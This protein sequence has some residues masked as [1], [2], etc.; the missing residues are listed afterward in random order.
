MRRQGCENRKTLAERFGDCRW[1]PWAIAGAFL[2]I[3]AVNGGLVYFAL[4]SNTGLA[5][6]A[7]YED[8]L[9][10]N[11]VIAEAARQEALGW[12]VAI[13]FNAARK[14][15]HVGEVVVEVRDRDGKPIS[16]LAIR[17]E[18]VRPVEPLPAVALSLAAEGRGRYAAA[19]AVPRPGQ[20]NLRLTARR[21]AEL[22]QTGRRIFV[23]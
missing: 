1:V 22:Y 16:D 23:P 2:V 18:L 14:G 19:V 3:A 12:Q 6:D 10:Y 15:G 20:W 21:E 13:A 7:A 11:A 17:G 9:A 4:A 8:G 5:D